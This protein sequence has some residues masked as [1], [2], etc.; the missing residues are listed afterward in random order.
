MKDRG[1]GTYPQRTGG[2]PAGG[3][4]RPSG[5]AARP[6]AA[7]EAGPRW[8]RLR[9]PPG[10][11]APTGAP[12]AGGRGGMPGRRP[13]QRR[14]RRRRRNLEEL[15]PTQLTTY[16]PSTAPVPDGEI[17]IERGSTA[18]DLGPEAEPQRR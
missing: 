18:R 7:T 9:R 10:G 8:R 15:E 12:P 14:A 16:Q 5:P 1:G 6:V 17:I 13:P 2:R 11:G 3:A 4:G